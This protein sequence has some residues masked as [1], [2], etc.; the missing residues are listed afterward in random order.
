[1]LNIYVEVWYVMAYE[2]DTAGMLSSFSSFA[3]RLRIGIA[4]HTAWAANQ[5]RY[6]DTHIN[7]LNI[8]FGFGVIDGVK[9]PNTHSSSLYMCVRRETSGACSVSGC[10]WILC[11]VH[12]MANGMRTFLKSRF[13]ESLSG[14]CLWMFFFCYVFGNWNLPS[15][16]HPYAWMQYALMKFVEFFEYHIF[17]SIRNKWTTRSMLKIVL[18]TFCR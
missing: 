8:R 7:H 5:N 3:M 2:A 18:N 4:W 1:M 9:Q 12:G 16:P 10:W 13:V 11:N 6:N 15:D 17:I 14:G